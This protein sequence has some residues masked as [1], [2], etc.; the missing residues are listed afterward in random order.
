MED[1]LKTVATDLFTLRAYLT[2][3]RLEAEGIECF[4]FNENFRYG[5]HV[6]LED[7]IELKV[8]SEDY[9]NAMQIIEDIAK[10]YGDDVLNDHA[11]KIEKIL[12]PVDFTDASLRSCEFALEMAAMFSGEI[13]LFHTCHL[14]DLNSVTITES[15][16][17][18]STI[19]EHLSD[20]ET[21][22]QK[23]L[24][25]LT[26]ILNDKIKVKGIENIVTV[27]NKLAQG[28][29]VDEILDY[30]EE[31]EPDI[32]IMGAGA[33]SDKVSKLINSI[34]AEVI[35][36][37]K[38]PV[39]AI[40]KDTSKSI[41]DIKNLMYLTNFDDSDFRAIHKLIYLVSPFKINIH[42][43]HI[44]GT[45][46][47]WNELK[48]NGLKENIRKEYI[49]ADINVGMIYSNDVLEG[50]NKYIL[51]NKI[52]IVAM[53]SHKRNMISRLLRP[54]LKRKFLINTNT[55]LFA[56]H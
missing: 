38:V 9:D 12:V 29:V 30:Y 8:R 34:S 37:V 50:C 49:T 22:A 24:T 10:E 16:I 26:D 51:D 41:K 19:D 2:K 11:I 40:P 20:L 4:L 42:C 52:D 35:E 18:S 13:T 3:G 46:D 7:G 43:V 28:F 17:F 1:T 36:N 47:K 27:L 32:I 6:N 33:P 25:K 23:E 31:Y 5:P 45:K 39:L 21:Y 44:S 15:G 14:P 48:L 54:G 53:V 56:F 55:P